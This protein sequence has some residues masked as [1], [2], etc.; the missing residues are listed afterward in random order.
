[1]HDADAIKEATPADPAADRAERHGRVLQEL[2]ELGMNLA[3][4]VSAEATVAD[5][6]KANELALAFSRIA[7]AVRQ[8][9]ALEA[10]L[11]EERQAAAA[12]ACWSTAKVRGPASQPSTG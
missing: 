2:T 5:P 10:K 9:L 3:R 12:A 8:T 4:A 7:R 1:M 11:A 6:A